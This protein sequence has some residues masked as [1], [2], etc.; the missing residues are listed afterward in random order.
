MDP[1]HDFKAIVQWTKG[2][3]AR[4][5]TIKP[6]REVARSQCKGENDKRKFITEVEVTPL[7]VSY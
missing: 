6:G 5:T 7:D 3:I 2:G 4:V 1:N